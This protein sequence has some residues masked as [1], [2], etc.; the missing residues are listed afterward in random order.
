[1]SSAGVALS[2]IHSGSVLPSDYVNAQPLPCSDEYI[3]IYLSVGGSKIP[4]RVLESDSIEF[5]KLRIQS[6]KGFVVKNQKL[7]CGGRTI[8]E[9]F[10]CP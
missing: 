8:K 3:F 5:V 7:V 10:S 6:C 4:M 2:P 9:Q 1:M